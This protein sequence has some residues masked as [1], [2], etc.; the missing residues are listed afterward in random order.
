MFKI[1][2]FNWL[3]TISPLAVAAA[4]FL[5]TETPAKAIPHI[6]V[7]SERDNSGYYYRRRITAPPSLNI[8]PPPGRHIPLPSS[9]RYRYRHYPYR[10]RGYYRYH[11]K[12]RNRYDRG[13][14]KIIIINPS[15][16][17]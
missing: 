3:K 12:N 11:D 6:S 4:I 13:A 10:D 5:A 9:S 1:S 16:R 8:T 15:R 14:K 7:Y 17:Y 2:T